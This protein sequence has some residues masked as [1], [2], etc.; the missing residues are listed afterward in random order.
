[1]K[2]V[3]VSHLSIPAWGYGG[4]ERVIWA[5]GKELSSRGHQVTFLCG[6]GSGSN[7][8]SIMAYDAHKPLDEQIP[9]DT[10]IVH[11]H[12]DYGV[13]TKFPYLLTVH[14]NTV[15]HAYPRNSVFVSDDH[16][17][18]H[19][20]SCF[21]YNG[22][23]FNPDRGLSLTRKT[24]Q[25][26]FLGKA[27]WRVKNVRGAIRVAELAGVR[28][29][30]VGGNRLNL[31]MGFR[32]TL[33]RNA[34]FHGMLGGER[35]EDI[36]KRSCGLIFPVRWHE[37]F[38]L[39]IIESLYYGAPVFGTPYGSLPELIPP[40]CGVLSNKAADLAS[41]LRHAGDFQKN[42]C[43]EYVLEKFHSSK[44]SLAYL[45]LYER[46]L[47]GEVLNEKEPMLLKELGDGRFLDWQQ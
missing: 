14:G 34:R 8:A 36:L 20:S 6:P 7:F 42:L 16:A 4:T 31:K 37:P 21:V 5:L 17:R 35:K 25:F 22:L 13:P 30:V 27:A 32:F 47:N 40:F 24:D 10:D 12:G 28:L 15:G 23:D 43:R 2:I 41:A 46:I 18:R 9:E 3:I 11:L 26:H 19:G 44:M 29:D 38:G 1:M 45:G 39:A 33:S